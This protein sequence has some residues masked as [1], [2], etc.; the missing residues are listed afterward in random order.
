MSEDKSIKLIKAV[1]ELNIG[2]GTIVDFLATKGYKVEKQPMAKLDSDMYSALLKEFAVDKSIKEEAKQISIGKIRKEEPAAFP[3][4][5]VENRRSRDFE[6][7]E[8]L[9]KNAGQ[10]TSPQAEKPKPVEPAPEKSDER[11][12]VLPGVKVVGKIDLNNLNAKPQ[13]AAEKTVEAKP[14]EV[15][16]QPEVVAPEPKPEPKVEAPKEV[17]AEAPKAEEPKVEAPKPVVAETPK[18]EEP[19]AP[20]AEQAPVAQAP[21][22]E[23]PAEDNNQE[24]DVIRAKAERLTGPNVIGKIQLPV[25][26]PKRNPVASSS[27]ANNADHK[28]K[29]KRKD[30]QGNPQ[31]GGQG[32]GNHPHQ[33]GGAHQGG[34][35]QGG[36]NQP[37]AGGTINPNRPDFRNRAN[38][39][40]AGGHNQGGGN[41]PDFRNRNAPQNNTPKEEP[42]EKDIQDQIKA[43]LAR[44]SGAGKSGKFA[45]RAKFRR[46]KRDDVASSAEELA[47]EQELQSKVLKVTEFVTANE[48]A[49]MMD[50]SV[51]QIISTCMSLGMFVSIN[52][53]LDAETLSIVADEFGYQIEFVKP[54]DEEANLDQPDDPADLVP[55]APIVTIMGHVDHGKTSLL[56]FIRKTNVIGGEAG[57]ITQ[58]IGAYE[59]TLPGDKGKITFL[60]T[61]GHEAFTAMRA[62]GAQVTDIVIIVIAADDSVMPQTREAINH[63]QAAGAP[64]IFAFNK[65]DKPGANADKVREQLST[66]NILVEEWGGKYQ[67]QEISAKTGLNIDLLL[68]KVLLEAELLELKAN[69]NKR[70]VGT[71]IEAALDKGRGIVTTILVQAGR[72]KVGDPILAGCYSGR[73]KALT[74]ERGQRVESA[75]PSTPVQVLGMQGAPTAGD[76]FNALES[77]PEA[78]EIANKR[79]QLQREQGLRTQKHITLDEIGRR[80]AVGNFKELNIIVKGDVDGSIEALSDS[81]LKLSTEQIQVNIISKAVG[82]ISESDVLLASASD[83]IIIGF[84]VRPSGSARKLAEAEQIDI[85]LYSIIYDAINEIKAAMEGM[86]APTFEEK[87][88]ANVEIRE[89]FKIS[90]VGTIA[91][92]MVLDGKINRNSKIRVIRDGV[93]IYTGEL[94]SLKRFKDDVKE[95]NA[96]YECGLNIQNFNNIEVGDIVEA[97]EN[98]EVK[99]KL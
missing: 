3:E 27:N 8:I 5:P 55:R 36:H 7:E 99:R 65:I 12:D 46:Q 14:V 24:P 19:K 33:G 97:Y 13:P 9:I 81:L 40:N 11:N 25:N 68:E 26:A 38:N 43:T 4:K 98:V 54:Q 94:A 1:K 71:V 77:E 89:T 66:M 22:V 67:T 32:G 53:R 34:S 90:K 63:A 61:P 95:V 49:L 83:A 45:Q 73:V 16:K 64:I 80:L 31:Q 48:L 47:L 39:P 76:K 2:M 28:R 15:A 6:N 79:L 74:N 60:D 20:V 17:V 37:P 82:Q 21:V 96:G 69:P 35:Q 78:R 92:C 44:L 59:V 30:N 42:S 84:Q 91:G 52:Q 75:G 51:T 86:L 29:R 18:P 88:V 57:G 62:R 85:R 87:I 50:V 41:R 23:T 72:L 56:D 58:H 10:Y 93:V 70:A